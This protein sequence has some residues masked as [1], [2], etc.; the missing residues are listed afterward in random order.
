MIDVQTLN[1]PGW[2]M[3]RGAERIRA[4]FDRIN[5]LIQRVNGQQPLPHGATDAVY[6]AYCAFQK[7]S[8]ANWAD[9]IVRAREER[10]RLVGFRTDVD[11]DSDGDQVA[12]DLAKRSRMFAELPDAV[13]FALTTGRGPLLVGKRSDGRPLVT[14]ED[15]RQVAIFRDAATNEITAAF[16]VLFDDNTGVQ[17]AYLYRQTDDGVRMW[18]AENKAPLLSGQMPQFGV[19]WD[20][21]EGGV[22]GVELPVANVPMVEIVARHGVGVFELHL[23]LLDRID[24]ET[25][26]GLVLVAFQAYKQRAVIGAPDEDDKGNLIDWDGLLA[27]GPGAVWRF[28]EGVDL[29]EFT[30]A[31]IRAVLEMQKDSRRELSDLTSTPLRASVSDSSNQSAEGAA[32]ARE[33]LV[34]SCEDFNELASDAVAMAMALI[35]QWTGDDQRSDPWGIRP[36]WA[37]PAR[38][39]LAEIGDVDAKAANTLPLKERLVKIWQYSPADAERIAAEKRQEMLEL[40]AMSMFAAP[41]ALP[42]VTPELPDDGTDD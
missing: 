28:P 15:P 37:D 39:S 6:E 27:A 16:K 12:A 10:I 17:Y 26:Q 22:A 9:A 5:G 11:G 20:W 13:H 32:F 14:A 19:S 24:H 30:E 1:T 41:L 36:I 34:F 21:G 2:W 23:D 42:P 35:G 38:R 18:T 40:Q 3:Q 4:Q 31:N 29:K 8:R 33:A 7:K 25:L